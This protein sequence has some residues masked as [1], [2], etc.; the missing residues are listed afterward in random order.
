MMGG[1]S[2]QKNAKWVKYVFSNNRKQAEKNLESI[3][4]GKL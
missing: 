2:S 3:W 4:A 1:G